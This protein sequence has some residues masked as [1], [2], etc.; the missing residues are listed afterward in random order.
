MTPTD[1]TDIPMPHSIMLSNQVMRVGW[2]LARAAVAQ[3]TAGHQSAG[4]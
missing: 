2:R 3:A 1:P 4:D